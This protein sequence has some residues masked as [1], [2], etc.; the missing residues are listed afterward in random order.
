MPEMRRHLIYRQALGTPDI[1]RLFP[2][3][4]PAVIKHAG[5]FQTKIKAITRLLSSDHDKDQLWP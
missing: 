4:N 3:N 1:I 5:L 2:K